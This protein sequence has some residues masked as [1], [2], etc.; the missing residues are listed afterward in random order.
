MRWRKTSG[1]GAGLP[2]AAGQWFLSRTRPPGSSWRSVFP[3]QDVAQQQDQAG[4]Q[5]GD[6][7][8]VDGE[9]VLQRVDPLLHGAGLE[10][11]VHP[12]GD[13][14]HGPHRVHHQGHGADRP[15]LDQRD[16]TRLRPPGSEDKGPHTG[17][18]CGV[19]V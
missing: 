11:V 18:V 2:Q 10:V 13:A 6:E 17:M 4:G 19:L 8:L 15:G 16:Q 14:P 12:G 9:E 3:E 7:Q 5:P 1:D